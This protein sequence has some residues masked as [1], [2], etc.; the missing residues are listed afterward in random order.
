[1]I[2]KLP[3]LLEIDVYDFEE[4]IHSF[5]KKMGFRVED[6]K[7]ERVRRAGPPCPPVVG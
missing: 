1:M 4:L 6:S 5:V 7:S 2:E 3:D